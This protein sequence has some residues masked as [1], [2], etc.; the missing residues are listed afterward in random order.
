MDQGALGNVRQQSPS[1]ILRVDPPRTCTARRPDYGLAEAR[2]NCRSGPRDYLAKRPMLSDW[3]LRLRTLFTRT[4]VE[5]EIDDE[6]RFHFDHQVDAYVAQGLD[7]AEA[8]R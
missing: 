6:L 1:Q 2:C 7:R 8:V 3:M 4:R 5:R